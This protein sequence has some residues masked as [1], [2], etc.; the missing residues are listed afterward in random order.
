M[1]KGPQTIKKSRKKHKKQTNQQTNK[2]KRQTTPR[3]KM[4][5]M[6]HTNSPSE[7]DGFRADEPERRGHRGWG[8][9]TLGL[10]LFWPFFVLFFLLFSW[11]SVFLFWHGLLMGFLG[12]FFFLRFGMCG[13]LALFRPF[14]LYSQPG[15]VAFAFLSLN[16]SQ[17]GDRTK[18]SLFL[19]T[20]IKLA[21]YIDAQETMWF[22]KETKKNTKG[23]G[24]R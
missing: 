9:A 24:V 13:F 23:F 4:N 3:K 14:L 18:F 16:L 17:R 5:K 11:F 10:A 22:F 7:S 20:F 12:V 15:L 1:L 8:R 2:Q 19:R 6:S 21:G